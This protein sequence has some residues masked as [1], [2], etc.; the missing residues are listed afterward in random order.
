VAK[1]WFDHDLPARPGPLAGLIDTDTGHLYAVSGAGRAWRVDASGFGGVEPALS[2]DGSMLASWRD[3]RLVLRD[4]RT[5]TSHV[6]G[7]VS[8]GG[9][10]REQ[11]GPSGDY[12]VSLQ[13]PMMWSPSGDRVLVIGSRATGDDVRALVIASDGSVQ[14]VA[15]PP[16][17]RQAWPAGWTAAG[18]IVWVS[19]P[20]SRPGDKV[21][22]VVTSTAGVV[23]RRVRL[24][25]PPGIRMAGQDAGS[26]SPDGTRILLE[27][28]QGSTDRALLASLVT[29]AA[30]KQVDVEFPTCPPSWERDRPRPPF[31]G[32]DQVAV[33]RD[34][35]GPQ[36]MVDPAFHA[37]CA[38]WASDALAGGA[39]RGV[40]GRLFGDSIQWWAWHWREEALLA[41]V[42]LALT[43]DL[44]RRRRRAHHLR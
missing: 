37:D 24:A 7:S 26:V 17:A 34:D 36:I 44:R 6:A 27:F 31:P 21:A 38:V 18:E 5:G 20:F 30:I 28:S 23:L 14:P 8:D 12:W 2:S 4:L 40:S 43:V 11:G 9:F 15:G 22:A 42:A 29:G 16:G 1:P 10:T 25:V 41:L 32:S 35:G 3:G 33:R 13:S 39:H 19:G